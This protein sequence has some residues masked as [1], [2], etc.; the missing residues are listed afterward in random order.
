AGSAKDGNPKDAGGKG[1]PTN[2]PRL[3]ADEQ[4]ADRVGAAEPD[5][6]QA[7]QLHNR[8]TL[9]PQG[10]IISA[11]LETALDSDLPGFARAVVREIKGAAGF[12]ASGVGAGAPRAASSM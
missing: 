9:A 8:S 5:H 2:G 6:A 11:V 1:S 7:S 3:N 12:C 10:T 4:F